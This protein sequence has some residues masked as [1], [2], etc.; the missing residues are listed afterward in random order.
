[1]LWKKRLDQE[2]IMMNDSSDYLVHYG[3]LGMKWGVR[4]RTYSSNSLPKKSSVTTNKKNKKSSNRASGTFRAVNTSTNDAKKVIDA[5]SRMSSKK[6]K[7]SDYSK[8][9]NE[10]LQ[11]RIN[12]LNLEQ[13][14]DRLSNAKVRTG[15]DMAK[16]I[17]DIVGGVAGIAGSVAGIVA[18]MKKAK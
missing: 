12:R 14:Y 10:E 13:Q 7:G 5:L 9:S 16:D 2:V 3:V 18:L 8:L 11:K 17:L 6:S 1:M 4:K 15:S